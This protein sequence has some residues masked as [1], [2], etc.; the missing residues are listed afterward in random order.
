MTR[1]F[2]EEDVLKRLAEIDPG[3][4]FFVGCPDPV[5]SQTITLVPQRLALPL[6][7][8]HWL[9]FHEWSHANDEEHTHDDE[10]A[11]V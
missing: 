1:L 5:G 3:V 8:A 11:G 9:E 6:C 4:C 2:T 10:E 7:A